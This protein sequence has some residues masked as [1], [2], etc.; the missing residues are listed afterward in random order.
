[1]KSFPRRTAAGVT[2]AVALSS[3][4]FAQHYEQVNLDANVSGAAE[5]QDTQLVNGWGLARSSNSTWWVSD[6]ANGVATL[7][8][9]PGDKQKLVVTIP[10]NNPSDPTFPQGTPTGI[11]SNNSTTDFA[12]TPGKT[13]GFIFATLDGSIAAWNPG[14]GLAPGAN[15]PSTNA[16]TV[17]HTKDGS[18]YTGITSASIDGRRYLYAANFLKGRIDVFDNAFNPVQLKADDHDSDSHRFFGDDDRPFTDD[19]LPPNFMP[20]NVQAIGNDIVV[21]YA[22]HFAGN[23][24]ETPGPGLGFVDIYS[25]KGRLLRRLEH[26]DWLNAPWGVV[27]APLDFGTFSHDLLISN[28]SAGGTT[29]SAGF[30]SAYDLDTGKF[31]GLL[32]DENGKPISING[33]WSMSVGNGS[34]PNSFDP[35]GAPASE[36]YF[37]AGPNQATG[38]LFG[39]LIPVKTD[40]VE[41]SSQ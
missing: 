10:K 9:G 34:T 37:T 40:L 6:E 24:F 13:A 35:D 33:I 29:Q 1:M 32:E 28:F 26:G 4:A 41:G 5:A 17:A 19:N 30:I 36:I 25:S 31:V 11:I 3:A 8:N 20:F 22:L 39:Y 21:T 15:P 18:G 7:Y 14:V 23:P 16:V 27:L 2:F 38:G 12:I